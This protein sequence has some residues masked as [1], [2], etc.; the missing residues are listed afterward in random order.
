MKNFKSATTPSL[1]PFTF[2]DHP[3]F[4]PKLKP[5]GSE[6]LFLLAENE[7]YYLLER[8]RDGQELQIP[9]KIAEY[10]IVG[11]EILN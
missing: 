2:T 11:A 7:E 5:F 6:K 1:I 10:H 9:K 4:Y 8:E 3:F